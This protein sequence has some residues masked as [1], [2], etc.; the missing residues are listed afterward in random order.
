MVNKLV[1]LSIHKKVL[2]AFG[3]IFLIFSWLTFLSLRSAKVEIDNLRSISKLT[4]NSSAILGISREIS[5]IQRL[6]DVYSKTGSSS[7]LQKMKSSYNLLVK[8]LDSIDKNLKD[9]KQKVG[10]KSLSK[11]LKSF[12]NNIDTLEKRYAN[13][14][15][16]LSIDLP[17]V[18]EGIVGTIRTEADKETNIQKKLILNKLEAV[19]LRITLY[20]NYYLNERNYKY[21]KKIK[22][23]LI[24]HTKYLNNRSRAL[25]I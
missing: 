9:E 21:K 6:T 20:S 1:N 14:K 18:L 2:L 12:G 22:D 13:R 7:I 5:E 15:R 16:I 17:L 11:A 23:E 3:I 19:W 10:V 4:K 8:D 24:K 25:S